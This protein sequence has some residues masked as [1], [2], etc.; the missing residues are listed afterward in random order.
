MNRKQ[1]FQEFQSELHISYSQIFTYLAWRRLPF[2]YLRFLQRA[3]AK[4]AP[5]ANDA[6]TAE[7]SAFQY[8]VEY[9]V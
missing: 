9:P 8:P 5:F 3:A 6:D 2:A 1:A 4:P 7:E